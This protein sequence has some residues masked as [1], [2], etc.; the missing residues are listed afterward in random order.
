M[1]IM[2]NEKKAQN[3]TKK[4]KFKYNDSVFKP[5][6]DNYYISQTAIIY[7]YYYI[8]IIIKYIAGFGYSS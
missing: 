4:D 1:K 6:Y 5:R 8:T 2:H 3:K 7:N